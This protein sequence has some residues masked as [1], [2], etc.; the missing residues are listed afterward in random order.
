[1][2]IQIDGNWHPYQISFQPTPRAR[3]RVSVVRFGPG[4][5]AALA[6]TKQDLASDYPKLSGIAIQRA[7]IEAEARVRGILRGGLVFAGNLYYHAPG[8]QVAYQGSFELIE[9]Y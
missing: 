3:K 1:M 4:M 8:P 9:T 7:G 5:E 6:Q 2:A